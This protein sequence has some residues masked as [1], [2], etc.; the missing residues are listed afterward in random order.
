MSVAEAKAEVEVPIE[1]QRCCCEPDGPT[2]GQVGRAAC[3]APEGDAEA[4]AAALAPVFP[5]GPEPV[6][7]GSFS[8]SGGYEII[9]VCREEG[10]AT[11][12]DRP[13][14]M[15]RLWQRQCGWTEAV[16][17]GPPEVFQHAQGL[18]VLGAFYLLGNL[19]CVHP[20]VHYLWHLPG[21]QGKVEAVLRAP[22]PA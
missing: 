11:G 4:L 3:A 2:W 9:E 17:Y 1:A 20:A 10:E 7:M 6:D 21:V 22:L 5:A 14:A 8:D 12:G 13:L 19:D 16:G 18:D 15:R